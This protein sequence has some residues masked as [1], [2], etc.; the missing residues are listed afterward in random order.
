MHGRRMNAC[1]RC[2]DGTILVDD[3][4]G[5]SFCQTCGCVAPERAEY[6]R[7]QPRQSHRERETDTAPAVSPTT[8]LLHDMGLSTMIGREN[9]DVSGNAISG[10]A[11]QS[12]AR[13]R[14][15]DKRATQN[16]H[17]L[18][19]I[20]T[21]TEIER[22]RKMLG[23]GGSV[24]EKAA[25]IYRKVH[26]SRLVY[27]SNISGMAA[28]AL[29]AA[30]REMQIRRTLKDIAGA[31]GVSAK[32]VAH[33]YRRICT[34]LDLRIPLVSPSTYVSRVATMSGLSE[35]TR[36]DALGIMREIER[37]YLTAGKNPVVLATAA[38]YI[39]ASLNGES[40]EMKALTN[41]S[42]VSDVSIRTRA[43]DCRLALGI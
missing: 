26:E 29:Y 27:C 7:G 1:G 33:Y 10:P 18:N 20:Q 3:A 37:Q 13:P 22:A 6:D 15:M 21:F 35:R 36:V 4:T 42:G 16:K 43:R 31:S 39:A 23:I 19:Y 25:Y 40:V 2:Q 30:S 41:A 28:A 24:A 5:E 14:T 34:R 11:L 12:M 9:R 32:M 17:R 38:L 8:L